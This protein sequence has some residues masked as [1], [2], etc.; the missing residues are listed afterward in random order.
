M[1]SQTVVARVALGFLIL[2]LLVAAIAIGG[3]RLE[4]IVYKAGLTV[5]WGAAVL[6]MIALAL[7]LWWLK[8]AIAKNS[9]EGKRMGLVALIG[10]LAFL[11]PLVSTFYYGLTMPAIHD[12]SSDP[13][14]APAFVALAA[15]RQAGDNS[16][17]FDGQRKIHWQGDDV[18]VSFA[19]HAYKNGLITHPHM[20]LMPG[21][22][23]PAANLFWRCFEAAKQMGWTIIDQNAKEGRI[24][25]QARS[26]W[27]G[28][29]SDVVIRVRPAGYMGARADIRA[30]SL[31]G[32]TD[33][34]FNI[35]LIRDFK[36]KS[37]T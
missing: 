4:R 26:P 16:V 2:A 21:S 25:A 29:I 22:T 1:R 7:A 9:G 33:N 15:K 27:F 8:G 30:E 32:E 17:M 20:K 5:M 10:A 6:G 23:D 36:V 37:G 24:E 19:L 13:D 34:G 35:F 11:Y 28:Q 31:R 3:V 14:R 12:A 18:T